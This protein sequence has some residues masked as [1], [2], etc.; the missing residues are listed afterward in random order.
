MVV[1][2]VV[3]VFLVGGGCGGLLWIVPEG[4]DAIM[5]LMVWCS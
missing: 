5:V 3:R 4:V 1:V 2:V